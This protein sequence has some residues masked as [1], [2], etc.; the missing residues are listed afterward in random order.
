MGEPQDP[1]PVKLFTGILTRD[2]SCLDRARE[3]LEN[4]FGPVDLQS[5]RFSFDLTNYYEK[6]MGKDLGRWFWSFEQLIDPGILPEVKLFTNKVE[7][8]LSRLENRIINL[9]PG[10][11]DFYKVI[12]ASV[13]DRA[14]KIY[15]NKGI[16]ADPTLHYLKGCFHCYE[17]SLP[18][19]KTPEYYPIFMEIRQKYKTALRRQ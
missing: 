8:Q 2:E 14:Q 4:Q 1:V 16:Y 15:L 6:E 5:L 10:Y 19:F 12:L 17:W 11:M 3:M 9:D 13:K 18:D 7:Q